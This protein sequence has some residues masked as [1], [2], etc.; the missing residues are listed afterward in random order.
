A[1]GSGEATFH[2]IVGAG[3]GGPAFEHPDVL[4]L[5]EAFFDR[6]LGPAPLPAPPDAWPRAVSPAPHLVT[7]ASRAWAIPDATP[8]LTTFETFQSSTVGGPVG[9]A[10][11]RPPG[12]DDD[13][14]R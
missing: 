8:P 3:H 7:V 6:H 2:T 4:R 5:V 12:H 1:S 14:D 10:L 9:Y 11:Y 13:P